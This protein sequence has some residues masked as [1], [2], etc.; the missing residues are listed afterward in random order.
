MLRNPAEDPRNHDLRRDLKCG[1]TSLQ[2][3]IVTT[4]FDNC[5]TNL[6]TIVMNL[7]G[8]NNDIFPGFVRIRQLSSLSSLSTLFILFEDC[9]STCCQ[10]G[11]SYVI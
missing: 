5:C 8:H 2:K 10:L 9:L 1:I 4:N 6:N 3:F 11:R 7:A